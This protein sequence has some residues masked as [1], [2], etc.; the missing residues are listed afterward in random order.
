MNK[1]CDEAVTTGER[2][3]SVNRMNDLIASHLTHLRAEGKS[4]DT[5]LAARYW[6]TAADRK[7][8]GGIDDVFDYELVTYLANDTWSPNTRATCWRHLVRFYRWASSGDDPWMT[9]NPMAGLSPPRGTRGIPNPV[10]DADLTYAYNESSDGWKVVIALAAFAGLRRAE[11]CAIERRHV[12]AEWV[13]VEH[14]KGDKTRTIP[15]H[16]DLWQLVEPRPAGHLVYGWKLGR[17]VS[18]HRLSCL[19]REHFDR[20]G[21]RHVHLHMCRD[22]FATKQIAAG[23]DITEVRESMGHASVATTQIY[24]LVTG[25]QRRLA[26]NSLPSLAGGSPKSPSA[27]HG[28]MIPT[29]RPPVAVPTSKQRMEMA[30]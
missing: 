4:P 11:I 9:G 24:V 27:G 18:P 23:H 25:G 21:L 17:P 10:S 13:R 12:D 14:G 8:P 29:H 6:L 7:L 3:V 1:T 16:P 5:I 2:S 30:R 28:D 20:L 15:T 22:W 26:V 19:A